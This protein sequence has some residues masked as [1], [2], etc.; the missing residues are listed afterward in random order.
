[1]VVCT[2]LIRVSISIH[3]PH[4]GRDSAD[5]TTTSV[6][7]NFN[8]RAPYG[9]R[10]PAEAEPRADFRISIHAPHTGRDEQAK[11]L[12]GLEN[13][14]QSTRPIRGATSCRSRRLMRAKFQSTRP[15]RGATTFHC[16]SFTFVKFQSTRPIRGAT[17]QD[18][19]ILIGL[20]ISIHAPH[21]GRDFVVKYFLSI[22]GLFQST[23]PIRGATPCGGSSLLFSE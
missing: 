1:M 9:A 6:F 19:S 14:F 22:F 15:I 17:L 11:E 4:T 20:Q 2:V 5:L 7:S 16:F 23:R 8:P 21:T 12:T 13:P 18:T 10:R 3:A